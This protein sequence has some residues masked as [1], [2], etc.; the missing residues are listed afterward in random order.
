MV[1]VKHPN[2]TN[3]A[4]TLAYHEIL[5]ETNRFRESFN[6]SPERAPSKVLKMPQQQPHKKTWAHRGIPR[7]SCGGG[8]VLVTSKAGGL[9][10]CSLLNSANTETAKHTSYVSWTLQ[11]LKQPNTLLM[12]PELCKHWN[13]QTHFLCFLNSTN[14]ETAKRTYYIFWTLQTLKQPNT[15]LCFL[16]SGNTETAK[17]TFYISWTLQTLKQPNTLS[18]FPELCKHWNSQTHFLHFQ[19]S[20]N[21]ETPN[22]I[23]FLNSAKTE[24]VNHHFPR[25]TVF[26]FQIP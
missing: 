2:L 19:N 18:T 25:L 16:N 24:I 11:T 15:L 21:T 5:L 17:H 1:G 7:V 10:G 13:S 22:F 26:R 6:T 4:D 3:T 20:T 12:F 8:L 9:R 14:T 23:C